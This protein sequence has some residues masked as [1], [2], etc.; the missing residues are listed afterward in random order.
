M[1]KI[2][3]SFNG[4]DYSISDSKLSSAVDS[5]KT[6][7][8]SSMSGSGA[9]IKFGNAD[10]DVDSTKLSSAAN[11]LVSH[12]GTFV[13]GETKSY[14]F[15]DTIVSTGAKI[16]STNE[17]YDEIGWLNDD[18]NSTIKVKLRSEEFPNEPYYI[19]PVLYGSDFYVFGNT[20]S[21]LGGYPVTL[22]SSALNFFIVFGDIDL[23]DY[24]NYEE[25]FKANTTRVSGG[26]SKVTLG[27]VSHSYDSANITEAT[28]T[29]SD[30]LSDLSDSGS[31]V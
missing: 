14:K 22:W 4:A 1:S 26:D 19:I 8:E 2:N 13:G 12:I 31:T 15:N 25:W 29:I 20:E 18:L 28:N 24:G 23:I 5:I 9:K 10:Y 3:I 21:E 17:E 6:H 7:L 30:A 27:G 11:G 16:V